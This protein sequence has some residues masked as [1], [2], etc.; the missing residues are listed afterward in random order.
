[1]KTTWRV[2]SREPFFDKPVH[3][4]CLVTSSI[5][6]DR[7]VCETREGG[8]VDNA[9]SWLTLQHGYNEQRQRDM[10]Y[11]QLMLMWN[12]V[13]ADFPMWIKCTE[14]KIV[15]HAFD[16]HSDPHSEKCGMGYWYPQTRQL[17]GEHTAEVVWHTWLNRKKQ[18]KD[19]CVSCC[20]PVLVTS[21]HVG[22]LVNIRALGTVVNGK[23]S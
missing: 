20:S 6:A 22:V 14:D 23:K 21:S 17:L 2:D 11:T 9:C 18:P 16:Y 3:H 1:M 12:Q 7:Y 4:S 8:R 19:S 5:H 13:M 15:R 10:A